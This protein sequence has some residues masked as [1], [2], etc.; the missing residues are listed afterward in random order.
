YRGRPYNSLLVSLAQAMGLEAAD[1]EQGG[2]AG[3][4][5]LSGNV[6]DQWDLASATQPL[7]LLA[8]A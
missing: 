7:P 4:G 3:I 8:S 5:D 6:F 2:Q 1:Y